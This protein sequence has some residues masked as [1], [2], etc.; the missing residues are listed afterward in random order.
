MKGTWGSRESLCRLGVFLAIVGVVTAAFLLSKYF[1]FSHAGYAGIAL[2]SLIASG[3]I[4]VP[5][6]ALAAVC[7]ASVFLVP[8]YISLTAAG[9]ETAGELTGYFLGYSGRGVVTRRP[10]FQRLE[11][12]TRQRGWLLLLVLSAVPNPVFDVAGVTAGVL[13]YP[14]WKFLGVVL[15]G[16]LVKFISLT[17]ACV[18][19]IEWLTG[20]LV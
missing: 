10:L 15:V 18:L 6:P 16:K 17:Y 2:S 13:R 20:L 3:G 5:V 11:G 4:V 14:L 1:D 7:V 19:G 9:A 12:W 8:L